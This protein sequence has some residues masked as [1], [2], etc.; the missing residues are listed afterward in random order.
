MNEV[1][2]KQLASKE[3]YLQE[4][5]NL[6]REAEDIYQI[7]KNVNEMVVVQGETIDKI[8]ENVEAASDNVSQGAQHLEQALKYKQYGYPLL[9]S[10]VGKLFKH[11]NLI[12]WR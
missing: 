3:A 4:F 1:R 10:I 2:K 5:E 11:F 12:K 8:E 9:G 7:Y 6:Q